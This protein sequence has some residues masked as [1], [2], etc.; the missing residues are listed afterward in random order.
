MRADPNNNPSI[1]FQERDEE[2][3]ELF[4]RGTAAVDLTGWEFSGGI[5]YDFPAG[6]SIPAGGY[7]IVAKDAAALSVKFPSV[8]I[9]GDYSGQLGNGGDDIVLEDSVGNPA[10]EVTY[11]DSRKWHD[12]ADGGGS[13]LR[14]DRSRFG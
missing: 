4:N 8:T 5:S 10:D 7:L 3:V 6:T 2:W 13:S 14:A 1:P 11:F 9:I 12:K